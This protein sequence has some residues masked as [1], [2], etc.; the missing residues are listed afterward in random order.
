MKK[1]GSGVAWALLAG[2]AVTGCT[3]PVD[4]T[5]PTAEEVE[6][7]YEY[8]GSLEAEVNGN[9]ATVTV[10]QATDQ[11]RRGGTLWA[12]M[13]P[14]IFLFTDETQALFATYPGLA[15]VRVVTRVRNG[16]EV[17]SALITRDELS[18]VQWRRALNISGRARRD[19]TGSLTLLEDLIRWGEDHTD[20]EYNPR[21]T[22]RR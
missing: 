19:G 5:L 1:R 18:D 22:S 20:F 4:L 9:V 16:P 8:T 15:G 17:A 7:V 12:K 2:M 3:E 10:V 11:L 14:Y 21:Y 13:G 6:S